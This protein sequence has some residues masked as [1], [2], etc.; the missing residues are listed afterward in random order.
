MKDR[1]DRLRFARANAGYDSPSEAARAHSD[2]N[3]NTLISHENGNRDFGK[4]AANKYAKAFKVSPGWLLTGEGAAPDG[5]SKSIDA[6]LRLL[7]PDEYEDLYNDFE[8]M[9]DRR[10]ERLH[11]N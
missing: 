6:K 1:K 5:S 4:A 2:I 11:K 8:A 3:K 7:P 9:I 10:L